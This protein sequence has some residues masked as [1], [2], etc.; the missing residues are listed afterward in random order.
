MD[1]KQIEK[2]MAAMQNASIKRVSIKDNGFEIE[3]ER[4]DRVYHT[5]HTQMPC[6]KSFEESGKKIESD[7]NFNRSEEKSNAFV[8]S[9]MIGTFYAASS[10]EDPPYV[11]VGDLVDENT[12]IGIIEAMKVMNE[13]KSGVRGKILEIL[14]KNGDPVEFGSRIF[15][16]EP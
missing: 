13:V 7:Q 4:E 16:I 1:Q 11:R 12:V 15:R 6:N 10:P 2:L 8:T 3:I 14:V 9:P 5:V